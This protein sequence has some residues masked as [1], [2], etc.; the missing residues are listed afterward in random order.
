MLQVDAAGVGITV[1][2]GKKIERFIFALTGEEK[3]VTPQGEKPALHLKTIGA[4]GGDVTEVWIGIERRLP[5]R[6]RHTDR[7][8]EVFD[9]VVEEMEIE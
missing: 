8:G 1:A 3:V 2:T 9:Q 5:L 6:I 4:A 7:K